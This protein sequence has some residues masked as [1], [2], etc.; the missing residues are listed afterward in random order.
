MSGEVNVHTAHACELYAKGTLMTSFPDRKAL[1]DVND[2]TSP[3]ADDKIARLRPAFA[4]LPFG[5]FFGLRP[6]G[7]VLNGKILE[8][9]DII[10]IVRDES[11]T[12]LMGIVLTDVLF[13]LLIARRLA[14]R[15][16]LIL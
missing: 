1:Y 2:T 9:I 5:I 13:V 10:A 6:F 4:F 15:F 14:I 16:V 11:M 12:S 3:H 8:D 7:H